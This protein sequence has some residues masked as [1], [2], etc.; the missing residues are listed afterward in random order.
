MSGQ[1]FLIA[2][3]VGGLVFGGSKL[4]HGVKKVVHKVEHAVG[5]KS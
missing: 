5:K 1:A 2:A 3:L 4:V